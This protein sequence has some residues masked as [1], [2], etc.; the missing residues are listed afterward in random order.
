[1]GASN[2]H[3]IEKTDVFDSFENTELAKA[4]EEED[5]TSLIVMG[6]NQLVCVKTTIE[7]TLEKGYEV[8]TSIDV[9]MEDK[10]DP[11]CSDVHKKQLEI[12]KSF[13]VTSPIALSP[14]YCGLPIFDR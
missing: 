5:I 3:Q 4:L 10:P 2:W 13:Y 14:T 11:Y 12:A 1:M 7:T 9:L 8:Y 6:Y